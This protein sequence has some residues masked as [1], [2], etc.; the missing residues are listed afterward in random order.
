MEVDWS[1]PTMELIDPAT[2][3]VLTV[4]LFVACL[5]FSRYS[6]VEPALDM[7]LDTWLLCHI[8]AFEYFGGSTAC[9][10][11]DNLKTGVVKHPSQ[12]VVAHGIFAFAK[13]RRRPYL[14]YLKHLMKSTNG[15]TTERY[16][17][18]AM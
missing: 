16:R 1:G 12:N 2:G 10:V 17:L 18:T 13:R 7:K 3:E 6:Y 15:F 14:L 5:P 8:H 9:I 11:P 4:Y